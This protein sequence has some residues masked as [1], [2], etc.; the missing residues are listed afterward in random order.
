MEAE[1]HWSRLAADFEN[2]NAYVAGQHNIEA[3]KQILR[4]IDLR[5]RVLELGCGNGTYS[6]VLAQTADRVF[7][8]DVSQDMLLTATEKLRSVERITV[9]RQDCL[10]LSYPDGGFDAAVMVNLLHIIPQPDVAVGEA[11]RILKAGGE[12]VIASFT[13]EGMAPFAKIALMYRYLRT[14]GKPP[15]SARVLTEE[16]VASMLRKAGFQIAETDLLGKGTRFVF[17]RAIKPTSG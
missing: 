16:S 1:N 2:R 7:A 9:E 5:G 11:F 17:V 15:A 10:G 12:L 6:P 4:S 14:Y 8:T 13:R 3:I